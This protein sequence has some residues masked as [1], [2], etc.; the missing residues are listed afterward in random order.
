MTGPGFHVGAGLTLPLL[1][2]LLLALGCGRLG[3][4]IGDL[5][6]SSGPDAA[7][8]GLSEADGSVPGDAALTVDASGSSDGSGIDGGMAL[9]GDS[10]PLGSDSGSLGSDSGAPDAG[11]VD[12]GNPPGCGGPSI[13]LCD[14]NE[15]GT[16]S[17][18]TPLTLDGTVGFDSTQVLNGS[19]SLRSTTTANGGNATM[20]SRLPG[21]PISSGSLHLR[22]HLYLPSS[23]PNYSWAG[24][25]S[26][27]SMDGGGCV[28][29][30]VAG[31]NRAT[32]QIHRMSGE[33]ETI[34]N[35]V[36]LPRDTWICLTVSVD[37]SNTSGNV[38]FAVDGTEVASYTDI[39]TLPREGAYND[40]YFGVAY[41]TPAQAP[42]DIFTDDFAVA[43]APLPCL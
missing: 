32:L 43:T 19:R 21:A 29:V 18:F 26:L 12:A 11:G 5:A 14:D 38:S 39:D 42:V 28:N 13:L 4:S 2:L 35:T 25:M 10:G 16:V 34:D 8:Q 27:C 9:G 24:V 7:G 23:D 15:D 22:T 41:T 30:S 3:Y 40:V 6:E 33:S 36:T 17:G 1:A 20:F 31:A 37:I